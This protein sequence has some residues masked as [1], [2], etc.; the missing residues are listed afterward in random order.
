MTKRVVRAPWLWEDERDE[1]DDSRGGALRGLVFALPA[2]V[3]FWSL[4]G[5]VLFWLCC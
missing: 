2:S 3:V 1:R 4:V 5:L